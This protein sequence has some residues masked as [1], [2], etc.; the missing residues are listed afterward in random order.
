MTGRRYIGHG[1]GYLLN[2]NTAAGLGKQE[3][4]VILCPH[5]QTV[6]SLQQWKAADGSNGWCAKCAAPCCGSGPCAAEFQSKGCLPWIARIERIVQNEYSKA[7]FRRVAGLEPDQ[8]T[9]TYRGPP[10]S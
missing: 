3:A 1:S 8:P 4:D 7:Q 6:I 10:T 9:L 2:D 5:C